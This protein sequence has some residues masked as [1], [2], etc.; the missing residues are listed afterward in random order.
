MKLAPLL[1]SAC[2]CLASIACSGTKIITNKHTNLDGNS[3]YWV[4]EGHSAKKCA[5]ERDGQID[6]A[7]YQARVEVHAPPKECVNGAANMEV[8]LD[9]SEVSRVRYECAQ[10]PL[11]A[12]GGSGGSGGLPPS[13]GLPASAGSA[14]ANPPAPGTGLPGSA[15]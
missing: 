5:G 7:G 8:V 4:C 2:G 13:A 11:P 6:P 14:G 15:P 10:P 3:E 12:S 1:L 9:G